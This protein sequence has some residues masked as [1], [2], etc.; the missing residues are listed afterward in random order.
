MP[1][2]VADIDWEELELFAKK[3]ITLLLLSALLLGLAGCEIVDSDGNPITQPTRPTAN[4]WDELEL[5][6]ELRQA[7]EGR[8]SGILWRI[9]AEFQPEGTVS[10]HSYAALDCAVLW[11]EL[12]E[13][14]FPEANISAET[15]KDGIVVTEYTDGE[16]S[17]S[18]QV[19][20]SSLQLEGLPQERAQTVLEEISNFLEQKL[21]IAL[22]QWTGPV[23]EYQ[24]LS[25]GLV[26]DGIPLDVKMDSP[27]PVS[28][29][30]AQTDGTIVLLNPILPG[31][32]QESYD[33]SG[34]MSPNELRK[35]A[36]TGWVS[37]LPMVMELTECGLIFY[38]DSS[39]MTIRP[40]W[41]LTGTGYDYDTGKMTPVEML[42]DAITGDIKRM[43]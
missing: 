25:Y 30:Y 3:A 8:S 26:I 24:W 11:P 23:P 21:D 2:P 6:S 17:F 36:E 13:A 34:C 12:R 42:I 4:D 5:D 43:R 18:V 40:G 7:I 28:C 39:E 10:V 16:Q 31:E 15:Q 20:S 41:S 9:P 29:L 37:D 27:V 38:L 35:T 19:Y 32:P 14:V 1:R 22:R 33:L